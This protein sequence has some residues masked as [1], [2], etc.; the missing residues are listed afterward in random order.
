M[1]VFQVTAQFVGEL[2]GCGDHQIQCLF[3][4]ARAGQAHEETDRADVALVQLVQIKHARLE[5]VGHGEQHITIAAHAFMTMEDIHIAVAQTTFENAL[6]QRRTGKALL[7]TSNHVDYQHQLHR[8]ALLLRARSRFAGSRLFSGRTGLAA[9]L[10][11]DRVDQHRRL[12]QI[13]TNLLWLMPL[14]IAC[15]RSRRAAVTKGRFGTFLA[16][17]NARRSEQLVVALLGEVSEVAFE[18]EANF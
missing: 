10:G 13:K 3:G 1:L 11:N 5:R 15:G 2:A 4:M 7:V 6:M 17:D 12:V 16:I 8:Q 14:F 9:R 18:L